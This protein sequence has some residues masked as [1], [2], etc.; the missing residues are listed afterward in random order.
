[1][2]TVIITLDAPDTITVFWNRYLSV[3][4]NV[5]FATTVEIVFCLP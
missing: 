4:G 2:D 5:N 1:M 3:I